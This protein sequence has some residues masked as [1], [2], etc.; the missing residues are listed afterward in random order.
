MARA[1]YPKSLRQA[2][3]FSYLASQLPTVEISATFYSL[4]SPAS[5]AAWRAA[6]P[7]GFVFAVKG[8]RYL[9]RVLRL[10]EFE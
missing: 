9:T 1:F 8:S 10:K 4:R 2:E 6:T 3:E 7:E 5:F